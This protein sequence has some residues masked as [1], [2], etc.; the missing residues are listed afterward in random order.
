MDKHTAREHLSGKAFFEEK[1]GM[2]LVR[3]NE[4]IELYKQVA[5]RTRR[6]DAAWQTKRPATL[7]R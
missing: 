4:L 7:P 1:H 5:G 6:S 2:L 3:D